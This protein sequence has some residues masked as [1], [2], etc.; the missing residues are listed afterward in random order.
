MSTL[1]TLEEL[2]ILLYGICI[3]R[4]EHI[5]SS[6]NK[7]LSYNEKLIEAQAQPK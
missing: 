6:K 1:A 2:K 7:S 5:L 4:F 3:F